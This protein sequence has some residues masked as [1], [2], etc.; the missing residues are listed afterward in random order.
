MKRPGRRS[1]S[2]EALIDK[3]RTVR[4]G[5]SERGFVVQGDES[6]RAVLGELARE[7]AL[8]DLPG[9]LDDERGT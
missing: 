8:A 9:P 2:I 7:R 4:L 1:R 3:G 6:R 5:G